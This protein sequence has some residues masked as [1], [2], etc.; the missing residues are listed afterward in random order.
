MKVVLD[1]NVFVS[2]L[3]TPFGWCGE[4]LRMA[5]SGSITLCVDT[6]ILL[7]YHE[8]LSRPKFGMDP[9]N[10]A[11]IMDCIERTSEMHT[12]A[13]LA[14][15]L[16]DEDDHPFLEVAVAARAEALVTGNLRHFPVRL[17]MSVRVLSP[18][19]FVEE[20]RKKGIQ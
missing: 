19:D 1:T 13:P 9:A 8:V 2:G 3:L 5:M 6:R 16:P 10:L 17:R 7:E 18:K 12:P 11:I 4:I 15:P 14:R 20:Y